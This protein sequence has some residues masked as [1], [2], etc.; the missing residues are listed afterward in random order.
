MMKLI[1]S[2]AHI[3]S[4][5]F[6]EDRDLLIEDS[7]VKLE[8]IVEIGCDKA[9]FEPVMKLSEEHKGFI[10][11]ALGIHPTHYDEYSLE[12]EQQLEEYAKGGKVV[13]IGEIGIDLYWYPETIDKQK[14]ILVS[15]LKI[16]KKYDLPVIIHCRDAFDECFKILEEYKPLKGV[17]HSFAGTAKQANKIIEI[18]LHI[19]L[20]GPITFKNGVDQRNVAREIPLEK[21]L[22]ET[23]APYLTPVPF[24]GKRNEP[25]Y[26]LY[27][28]EAIALEKKISLDNVIEATTLNTYNLFLKGK[29]V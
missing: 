27:V 11:P 16:A 26:V 17:M 4:E 25:S 10:F 24:R 14:Q 18:G 28:A 15:Q 6:N 8:A 21:L 23:D 5:Q 13:A 12:V 9:S 19:G 20:S 2:H 3:L 29:N 1:D 7:R 22:V